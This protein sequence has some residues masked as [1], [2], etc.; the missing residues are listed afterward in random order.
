MTFKYVDKEI[1]K[2]TGWFYGLKT[3]NYI[4]SYCEKCECQRIHY[5]VQDCFNK[6]LFECSF[7]EEN[8]VVDSLGGEGNGFNQSG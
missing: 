2:A 3:T 4:V 5:F 1:L 7:C 6:I 8:E